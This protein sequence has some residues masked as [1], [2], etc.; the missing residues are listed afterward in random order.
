MDIERSTAL[1]LALLVGGLLLL[2]APLAVQPFIHPAPAEIYTESDWSDYDDQENL[3]YENLSATEQTAFDSALAAR[4]G[5]ANLTLAEAPSALTPPADGI[6]IYNVYYQESYHLLQVKH[7][8]YQPD[9]ATQVL[10][11][12]VLAMGGLLLGLGGGYRQFA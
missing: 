11:R 5:T 2:T 10:P 9:F 8:T 7:V 1:N 12:V 3:V 4:P 6:D